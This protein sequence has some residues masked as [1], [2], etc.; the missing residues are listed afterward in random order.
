MESFNEKLNEKDL[1][2]IKK[3]AK[4]SLLENKIANQSTKEE[5]SLS[6]E[7]EVSKTSLNKRSETR[8]KLS[9]S[10]KTVLESIINCLQV[11]FILM[12]PNIDSIVEFCKSFVKVS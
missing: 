12:K 5:S 7:Y 11:C 10:C 2:L 1:Q 3:E 9:S 6:N 4:I 8:V